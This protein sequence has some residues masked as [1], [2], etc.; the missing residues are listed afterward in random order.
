MEKKFLIAT[1]KNHHET[2]VAIF[3]LMN[4][5]ENNLDDEEIELLKVMTVAAEKYE[6]E[7]L[8]LKS[9][10]QPKQCCS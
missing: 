5:G 7:V 9:L 8:H 3:E 1:D 10:M 4:K 2:M 6:D